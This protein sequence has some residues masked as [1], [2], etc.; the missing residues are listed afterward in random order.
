MKFVVPRLNHVERGSDLSGVAKSRLYG[1][2][3][4]IAS[5]HPPEAAFAAESGNGALRDPSRPCPERPV[6]T[7]TVQHAT[8]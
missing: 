3:L 8:F 1:Q 6:A 5:L 4:H 2:D 7:A